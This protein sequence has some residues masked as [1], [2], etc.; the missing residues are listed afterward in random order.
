MPSLTTHKILAPQGFRKEIIIITPNLQGRP[1][2]QDARKI[3]TKLLVATHGQR[4]QGTH[5]PMQTMPNND[6]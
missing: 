1:A 4:H 6:G 2:I 5:R 3:E